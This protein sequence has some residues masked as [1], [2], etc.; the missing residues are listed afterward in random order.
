MFCGKC[1]EQIPDDSQAC[2]NCGTR[3]G[4]SSVIPSVPVSAGVS[5]PDCGSK[6]LQTIVES[7][8][9]G[10][11]GGY[12]TGK[13]CLG[14]LLFGPLGLLCGSCGSKA[15]VT[16]TNKTFWV[17]QDCGHKFRNTEELLQETKKQLILGAGLGILLAIATVCFIALWPMARADEGKSVD[18]L[19]IPLIIGSLALT[20]ATIALYIKYKN[21]YDKIKAQ[22]EENQRNVWR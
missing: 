5:C 11:G 6:N 4:G 18:K 9:S 3:T 16:T 2:P 17:C 14:F 22:H 7:N 1:G 15:K 13:G 8:T 19:F 12:G 20:A 21:D 10:S